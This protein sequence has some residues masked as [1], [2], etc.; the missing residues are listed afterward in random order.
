MYPRIPLDAFKS[1]LTEAEQ[2]VYELAR[3]LVPDGNS[4]NNPGLGPMD[5]DEWR[6][7]KQ[8]INSI[9]NASTQM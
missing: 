4:E 5:F 8:K 9:A 2:F 6:E 3:G 1:V 7:W